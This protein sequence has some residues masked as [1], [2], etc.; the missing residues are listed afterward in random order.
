MEDDLVS[1]LWDACGKVGNYGE[2]SLKMSEGVAGEL[3]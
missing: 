2:E 3:Q 1:C